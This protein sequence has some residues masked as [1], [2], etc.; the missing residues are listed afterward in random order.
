MRGV[1]TESQTVVGK[2]AGG[3]AMGCTRAQAILGNAWPR[4]RPAKD[5]VLG[6][7][8]AGRGNG[9]AKGN[10]IKAGVREGG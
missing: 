4:E 9:D 8:T 7:M 3:F 6:T 2:T 1:A 5:L 10:V